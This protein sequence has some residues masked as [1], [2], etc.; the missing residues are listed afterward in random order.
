MHKTYRF[1][2]VVALFAATWPVQAIELTP[3]ETQCLW[4]ASRRYSVDPLL[5]KAIIKVESG[6]KAT[7]VGKNKNGSYDIGIMQINSAWLP[8]LR[9]YGVTASGL[10]DPCV[11]IHVGTWV[12]AGNIARFGYTWRALGA[13]NAASEGKRMRYASKVM[14]VWRELNGKYQERAES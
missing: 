12:L 10:F 14:R 5:L 4:D 13:Y 2:L 1:G 7:A 9:K 11:N 6:G 3:A 8:T